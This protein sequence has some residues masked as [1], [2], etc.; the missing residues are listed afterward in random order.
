MRTRRRCDAVALPRSPRDAR[1]DA[2]PPQSF[3][4]CAASAT[5]PS[6]AALSRLYSRFALVRDRGSDRG[7]AHARGGG[8]GGFG[9]LRDAL[10]MDWSVEPM[11]R[12]ADDDDE[13]RAARLRGDGSAG[14]HQQEG[15]GARSAG[16]GGVTLLAYLQSRLVADYVEIVATEHTR[17]VGVSLDDRATAAA[18][19]ADAEAG[20]C[21]DGNARGGGPSAA[22]PHDEW[23]W[24]HRLLC[25]HSDG[26]RRG[27]SGGVVGGGGDG[28]DR[29]DGGG[30][31]A[32][33]ALSRF[34]PPFCAGDVIGVGRLYGTAE[35]FFTKVTAQI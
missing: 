17:A 27:A 14:E 2:A 24:R 29:G 10:A 18:A 13:R 32:S 4:L 9:A 16:G 34:G 31:S 3:N 15:E 11:A 26:T 33:A 23:Q 12:S 5:L 28:G 7:D 30:G 21:A 8:A 20:G 19:A 22:A 25:Y 35:L 6:A 1:R